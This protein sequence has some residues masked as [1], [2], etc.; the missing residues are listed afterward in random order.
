MAVDGES[1][2]RGDF[3]CEIEL[4]ACL[5]RCTCVAGRKTA[6]SRKMIWRLPSIRSTVADEGLRW[7]HRRSLQSL[8]KRFS[9]DG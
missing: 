2:S 3:A 8:K 6:L 9:G 1:I 5:A 4:R 7:V